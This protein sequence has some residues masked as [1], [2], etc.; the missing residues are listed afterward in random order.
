MIVSNVPDPEIGNNSISTSK[1]NLIS[2][3]IFNLLEQFTKP[4]NSKLPLILVYFLLVGILQM[5]PAIS[6]S[7][8]KPTMFFPLVIVVLVSMVKDFFED[9]KRRASDKKENRSQI[10]VL[11]EIGFSKMRWEGIQVGNI[12]KVYK[13]EYFPCDVLLIKHS[14]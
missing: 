7:E 13:D 5:I 11:G 3:P 14:T 1:Y 6:V 2:F 8:G 12:I 9:W 4:S 10:E